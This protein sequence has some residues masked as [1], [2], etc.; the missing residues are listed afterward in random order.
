M[1]VQRRGKESGE[2]KERERKGED[3]GERGCRVG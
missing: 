3:R 2:R 1:S